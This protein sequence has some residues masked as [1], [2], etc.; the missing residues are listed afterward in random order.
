MQQNAPPLRGRHRAARVRTAPFGRVAL[1]LRAAR[2]SLG[3][4]PSTIGGPVALL[5]Q[6]RRPFLATAAPLAA[7]IMLGFAPAAQAVC[8][9]SCTITGGGPAETDCHAEFATAQ[10]LNF[11]PHDPAAPAPATELRC[12]DGEPGCDLDALVHQM[13]IFDVDVCLINL[14]PNRVVPAREHHPVE[15]EGTAECAD[16]APLQTALEPCC[17]DLE[18][19]HARQMVR[20]PVARP[21]EVGPAAN[22]A[23]HPADRGWRDRRDGSTCRV[24]RLGE[25]R[26]QPTNHRSTPFESG[27]SPETSRSSRESGSP[28]S[29]TA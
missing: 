4:S 17:R 3:R 18:R 2:P 15:V 29:A 21:G 28:S 8:P 11:P 9:P 27:I 16:L 19:L 14:D 1:R 7:F 12:Y 24:R 23:S 25:P 20:V 26:L 5:L 22:G 13:C 10:S 6:R